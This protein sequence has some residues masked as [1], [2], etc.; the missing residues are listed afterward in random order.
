MLQLDVRHHGIEMNEE[1]LT[2]LAHRLESA[3]ERFGTR[4]GRVQVHLSDLHGPRGGIEQRCCVVVRLQRRP[5]VVV[6]DRDSNL[7][8]LI[9]RTC[10][11]TAQAVIRELTRWRDTHR[12]GETE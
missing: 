7:D 3:L 11:R 8:V 1:T 10:S 6:E 5:D 4:I 12:S 2:R 9:D